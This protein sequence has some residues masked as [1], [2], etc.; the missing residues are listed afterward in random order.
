MF[1]L[2]TAQGRLNDKHTAGVMEMKWDGT[3]GNVIVANYSVFD[4][5]EAAGIGWM[6]IADS[7]AVTI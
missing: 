7:A 6:I 4:Y 3:F 1:H 5:L 2:R